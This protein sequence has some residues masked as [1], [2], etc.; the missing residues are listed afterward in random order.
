MGFCVLSILVRRESTRGSRVFSDNTLLMK[1]I[2]VLFSCNT[3]LISV[4]G[5]TYT[6]VGIVSA[7]MI[8]D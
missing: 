8:A 6:I 7:A 5:I 4:V 2:T 3:T 1:V